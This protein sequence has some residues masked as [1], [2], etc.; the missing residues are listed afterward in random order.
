MKKLLNYLPVHFCAFLILGIYLQFSY[1]LWQYGFLYLAYLLFLVFALFLVIKQKIIST[2]LTFVL[3]FVLGISSVYLNNY[4]NYSTYYEKVLKENSTV[5]LNIQK[6]LKSGDYYNKYEASVIQIDS[7]K[8]KGKVLLNIKKD[9]LNSVLQVNDVLLLKPVFKDMIPPLN[10]HQFNYKSYLK[11]QGIHQQLFINSNDFL[12]INSDKKTLL[13]WAAKFREKVQKSL[14][15]HHFSE[16]EFGVIN[17]LLLGQR[18]DISKGLIADYSK[19]GA[20]HILAVSGLHVGIILLILS[21]LLK[22]LER[23]KNGKIIKLILIVFVL[24]MFAL[25]AGLSASVV[26]A[27]TMFTFLAFGLLFRRKNVVAFSLLSSLFFLLLFNPMFLFDVGFQLSYLAVFGII[28]AQP[29]LAKYW[30]PKN[31][32]KNFFWQLFTVSL[33]AQ[34]GILP[35]SIY[36]FHQFPGLFLLS[37]LCIIPFLGAILMGGILVITLS[38]ANFLPDFLAEIYGFV[39]SLMNTFVQWISNQETFLFQDLTLSFT[40]MLVFYALLF[41]FFRMIFKYSPKKLIFFLLS[42][43]SIQIVFLIERQERHNKKEFVVFHKSR[44]SIIG[45]RTG[46]DLFIYN[47][48]DSLELNSLSL[49][50]AYKIG[51]KVS[52]QNQDKT[53]NI[54]LFENQPILI[55]D[56]LGVYQLENVKDPIVVLQQ[57]PKINLE[58]LIRKLKPK[59]IVADGSNFKSYVNRWETTCNKMKIPFHYTGQNGAFLLKKEL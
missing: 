21:W 12:S 1:K 28:W 23:L 24:W 2:I 37:N 29:K 15:K 42:V 34:V 48:L 44:N 32:I 41:S 30:K 10:P 51:E 31:K 16:D 46:E 49:L 58:R 40:V 50:K 56:S 11:K 3:F 4:Q 22:P 13:G 8:T 7:T 57:S 55:I 17:A 19:A 35:L 36:Y 5:I 33:A 26:R 9:S 53:P 54:F 27:V 43:V 47:D 39:I 20:I 6:V 59:Q 18:H 14:K 45:D 25:I 38:V 52:F